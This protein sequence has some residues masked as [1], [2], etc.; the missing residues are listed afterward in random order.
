M[1]SCPSFIRATYSPSEVSGS[2]VADLVEVNRS[3]LAISSRLE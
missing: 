1:S 2:S 3:S